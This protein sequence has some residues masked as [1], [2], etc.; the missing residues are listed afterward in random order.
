MELE[1]AVVVVTGATRGIG[2]HAALR[3]A[4]AGAKV[5]VTGRSSVSSPHGAL[6][7]SVE[8]TVDEVEASG[9][10]VL[11]VVADLSAAD[12]TREVVDRTLDR[13]GRCDVLV[14]NAALMTTSPLLET[15]ARRFLLAYQVNV[16]SVVELVQGF[17]PAMLE[18]GSGRVI[19]VSSGAAKWGGNPNFAVYGCSKAALERLNDAFHLEL[20]GRGVTFNTLRI[21]ETVPTEM[22]ELSNRRGAVVRP[23]AHAAMYS[24][25]QTA[26][27]MVWMATQPDSWSGNCV[28][29]G[30]LR[31]IGV[32]P[33]HGAQQ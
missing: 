15:P 3:F 10:E 12:G 32:L 30:D 6:P 4:A 33:P 29:F 19:S 16:V 7:G 27:A 2:R 23:V 1:G 25:A 9:G 13:F 26:E 5:V 18:R 22:Y 21:D 20:G 17:V 28:G 8:A 11:G 24:P 31:T 14:A